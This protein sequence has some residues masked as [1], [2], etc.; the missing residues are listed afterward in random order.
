[1]R[2][3]RT[4]H[5]RGL[6]FV[7]LQGIHATGDIWT[8]HRKHQQEE[9]EAYEP[10][11]RHAS[12]REYAEQRRQQRGR[13]RKYAVH[14]V[15]AARLVRAAVIEPR[16]DVVEDRLRER[17]ARSCTLREHVRVEQHEQ[18]GN[19]CDHLADGAGALVPDADQSRP[20]RVQARRGCG[21]RVR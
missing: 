7:S 12:P 21:R 19:E 8:A 1:M 4:K 10:S 18:A 2:C 3:T 6:D 16:A 20:P 15:H 13:A 17:A 11:R 5:A 9:G 14:H